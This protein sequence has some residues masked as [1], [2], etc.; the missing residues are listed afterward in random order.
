M[1]VVE[2]E[3][4]GVSSMFWILPLR[5]TKQAL[6]NMVATTYE[7]AKSK[8]RAKIENVKA[9]SLTSDMLTTWIIT[10]L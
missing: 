3:G 1:A 7:D 6:N 4:L 5:T 10:L 2:N 9:V 8:A